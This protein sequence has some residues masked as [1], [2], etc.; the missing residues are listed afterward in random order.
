MRQFAYVR[1]RPIWV[2][3][4]AA[5]LL[6]AVWALTLLPANAATG[7]PLLPNLVADPPDGTSLATDSSTGTTRLLLRF[8]GYIRNVGPGAVD[9]RGS[10]E[11]PKVSKATEEEVARAKEKQESLPQ[12]TEEELAVPPMKVVQRLFTTNVGEGETNIERPHVDE[13]SG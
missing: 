12:K 2:A 8:N 1:R 5:V 9:F 13:P 3:M 6:V 4:I 7:T 11:K 10:R